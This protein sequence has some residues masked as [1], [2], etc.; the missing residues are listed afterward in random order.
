[1]DIYNHEASDRNHQNLQ[2]VDFDKKDNH[3][4]ASHYEHDDC[5]TNDYQRPLPSTIVLSMWRRK[6]GRMHCV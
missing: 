5:D 6:L 2:Q 3:L 1:M 4:Q